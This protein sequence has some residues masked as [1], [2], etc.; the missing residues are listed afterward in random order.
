MITPDNR[1]YRQMQ[2]LVRVLP[3]SQRRTV[4]P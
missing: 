3:M 4:L 1:Y 2:L